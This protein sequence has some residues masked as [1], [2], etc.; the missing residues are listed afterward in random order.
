MSQPFYASGD[1]LRFTAFVIRTS[2]AKPEV[3]N[4]ILQV[5]FRAPKAG[6]SQR[7]QFKMEKGVAV[8]T[9]A[10]PDSLVQGIYE[11]VAYSSRT[12]PGNAP[13]IP[14]RVLG[15]VSLKDAQNGRPEKATAQ[16]K[17]YPEGGKLVAGAQGVV[18]IDVIDAAQKGYEVN[19]KV[20][21]SSGKAVS[22]FKTDASGKAL[23][24]FVPQDGQTYQ[25]QVSSPLG[26]PMTT[27]LPAPVAAGIAVQV[28]AQSG[29]SL[30]RVTVQANEGLLQTARGEEIQVALLVNGQVLT[31]KITLQQATPQEVT[32]SQKDLPFG[33]AEVVLV[34]ANGQVE[35]ERVV[36]LTGGRT[37]H[38]QVKTDRQKYGRR[39]QVTV[40]VLT[41]DATGSPVSAD[42]S[43]AVR[44]VS[45]ATSGVA[46]SESAVNQ[47]WQ[48][49][50]Q[51][52][53]LVAWTP[54]ATPSA[55]LQV[56]HSEASLAKR[57]RLVNAA[58]NALG[59]TT[60]VF[61]GD[62]EAGSIVLTTQTDGS[63]TLENEGTESGRR[64]IYEA[65]Q[66]GKRIE[67]AK[68][69]WH[70]SELN[71]ISRFTSVL[72]PT[73]EEAGY[74]QQAALRKQVAQAFPAL[75]PRQDEGIHYPDPLDSAS[76]GAPDRFFDLTKYVEFKTMEEVIKEVLPI[77]D[78]VSTKSGKEPR[79]YS[80][81]LKARFKEHPLYLVN[82]YPTLNNQWILALPASA[83]KGVGLYYSSARLRGLGLPARNGIISIV[84]H[85]ASLPPDTF[86]DNQTF[87]LEGIA[88]NVAF[89]A[90]N[91]EYVAK[92][93]TP[94][95]R[96]LLHWG[97]SLKTDAT[98]KAVFTFYTSD[99]VGTFLI[100]AQGLS[101][102]STPS[103][104]Q[105]TFKVAASF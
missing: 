101:E 33:R 82:G 46:D 80:L 3:Q 92:D 22:N 38:V 51:P 57:G 27:T 76:V 64:L 50:K 35:G 10:L 29:D 19:G 21:E 58:G 48:M 56:N 41:T 96:Y 26:K 89:N 102:K 24:K 36:F 40:T 63:F 105:Q 70:Q 88:K 71:L 37:L 2:A 16:V 11:L 75:R 59:N 72:E 94:D 91:H 20:V 54:D 81:D 99:D 34:R 18:A 14:V 49:R 23:V 104:G 9:I 60:L 98:G 100:E 85:N 77:T 30:V 53:L 39:E 15:P 68:I 79:I 97:P 42:L 86:K 95:F 52:P 66:G 93:R 13:G 67:D 73:P 28:N 8:G 90:P 61:L 55:S 4:G 45:D 43:V 74:L 6:Q 44:K 47:D 32:F 87:T 31:R 78:L 103:G 25:V 7:L 65:L 12:A 62:K 69:E 84:T 17:A 5:E 83:V 1:T